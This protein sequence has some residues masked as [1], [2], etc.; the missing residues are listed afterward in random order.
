MDQTAGRENNGEACFVAASGQENMKNRGLPMKITNL[1]WITAITL[2]LLCLPCTSPAEEEEPEA[3][4]AI[5]QE[6]VEAKIQ[7]L[8]DKIIVYSENGNEETA[9]EFG[10]TVDQLKER[11]DILQEEVIYL[12]RQLTALKKKESLD[13]EKALLQ[14]H[15]ASGEALHLETAPPYPVKV[16]DT[17]FDRLEES[18]RKKEAADLAL[19]IAVKAAGKS[20]EKVKS[21]TRDIRQLRE[22][23]SS[24]SDGDQFPLNWNVT[25][26]LLREKLA[27]EVARFQELVA[28]NSRLEQ[29][30]AV[31]RLDIDRQIV[32]RVREHLIF[33][34]EEYDRIIADIEVKEKELQEA[35]DS[36]LKKQ[37][38]YE[39]QL[40]S[41]QRQ[42][43]KT[44][45][46]ENAAMLT[47][48][49]AA[50]DRW[51]Q[52]YQDK[53]ES[54]EATQQ[55]CTLQKRLWKYRFAVLDED[56]TREDLAKWRQEAMAE[57]D[58][59]RMHL[60]IQQD[61]LRDM[62]LQRDGLE[63]KIAD[64]HFG[65]DLKSAYRSELEALTFHVESL[66]GYIIALGVTNQLIDRFLHEVGMVRE[67]VTFGEIAWQISRNAASIWSYE[68][69]AVDGYSVTLGKIITA[70]AIFLAGI[71]I[72]RRITRNIHANL[73]R[74]GTMS[75]SA[76]AVTEKLIHYFLILII[77]LFAM[78]IVNIPLTAFAYLGGAVAIGVGF[79]AQK[80]LGNFIS[81]FIL[82]AEQPVKVG[83]LVQMNEQ[84]GWIEDIGTRATMV[85][86]FS[87]T[88]ILVPNSY[89]LE[90]NIINWT[91]NDNNIRCEIRVGVS[92]GTPT[93][94]VR[95]LLVRAASDHG[96][97]LA[98]P[99]PFVWLSD[100]GDN[101][102]ILDLLFWI[103]ITPNIGR[104]Q[105]ES[106][107]RFHI[108]KIFRE[109][110]II[111][112]FPQRDIHLNTSS[113]LQFELV[114]KGK[115][116]RQE[117]FQP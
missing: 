7:E 100:F 11:S 66:P 91:L 42:L 76:A 80:L 95:D 53:L 69:V 39:L 97:V 107:V 110:G 105:I 92:Y 55:L 62:L 2:L 98:K 77:V 41:G 35:T 70:L 29:A 81:G 16:Y 49:I 15:I 40:H 102:L 48:E 83:D 78:R 45:D 27:T 113:P 32:D 46:K 65:S 114:K 101:A 104:Q 8:Q 37:Q 79:G 72:S 23:L 96:L 87:N 34:Q 50:A 111:V 84:L 86:T 3:T 85:R 112:A 63:E 89:F 71:L 64:E 99:A 28:E 103:T 52:A 30:L 19:S 75:E 57:G 61:L 73:R 90:N 9:R 82:M 60:S 94:Q 116:G 59:L 93:D 54:N 56:F 14:E 106:D 26:Q 43:E 20:K 44:S 74:R 68:I 38:K 36:L 1:F 51:R 33:T 117:N 5:S 31:M 88:H 115:N 10:I 17:Y 22:E 21:A 4:V 47:A 25:I 24:R 67:Q 13:K 6:A 108:D 12:N 109:E 18:I 58:R